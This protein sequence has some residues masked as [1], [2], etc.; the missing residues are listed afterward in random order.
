MTAEKFGELAADLWR[1]RQRRDVHFPN[2]VVKTDPPASV[3]HDVEGDL[4]AEVK[5]IAALLAA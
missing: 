1:A 2:A 3:L 5:R 4:D